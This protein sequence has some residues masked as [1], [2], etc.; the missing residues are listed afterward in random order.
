MKKEKRQI[1]KIGPTT[2]KGCGDVTDSKFILDKDKI[3]PICNH[4]E[5][6][7]LVRLAQDLE[8]YGRLHGRKPLFKS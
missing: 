8:K 3:G 7:G 2:C 4:C 1:K 6:S 5:I